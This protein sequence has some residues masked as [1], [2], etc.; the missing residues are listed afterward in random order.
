[1]PEIYFC[2]HCLIRF[3][4]KDY[5]HLHKY[6]FHKSIY[7]LPCD[8]CDRHFFHKRTLD[9]HVKTQHEDPKKSMNIMCRKCKTTYS[10]MA[11]LRKHYKRVHNHGKVYESLKPSYRRN[12]K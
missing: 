6:T 12:K 4:D 8:K 5:L 2:N 1:M 9:Q 7:N 10:S 11:C 3:D